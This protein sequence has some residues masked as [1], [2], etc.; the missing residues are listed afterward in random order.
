MLGS[1]RQGGYFMTKEEEDAAI[2]RMVSEYGDAKKRHQV[3]TEEAHRLGAMF[4]ELGTCLMTN[5]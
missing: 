5:P 3:L 2:G 1:F 4:S